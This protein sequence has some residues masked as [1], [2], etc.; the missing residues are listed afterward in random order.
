MPVWIS[1]FLNQSKNSVFSSVQLHSWDCTFL[2]VWMWSSFHPARARVC[3]CRAA[4]FDTSALQVLPMGW[5][6][7][8]SRFT[9]KYPE[10]SLALQSN[11]DQSLRVGLLDSVSPS[12]TRPEPPTGKLFSGNSSCYPPAP[13]SG[14]SLRAGSDWAPARRCWSLFSA[15]LPCIV[16]RGSQKTK[17]GYYNR[18]VMYM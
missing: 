16:T 7:C 8:M 2:L 6:S 5:Q 14:A 10:P 9:S 13:L 18:D 11:N 15:L 17:A 12:V 3:C 1:V 4:L